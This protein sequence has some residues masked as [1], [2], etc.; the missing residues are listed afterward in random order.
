MTLSGTHTYV[1]ESDRTY[2]VDPGPLRPEY[3]GALAEW[4]VTRRSERPQVSILLSHGHPDHSPGAGALKQ[5]LDAEVVAS[6]HMDARAAARAGVDRRFMPGE[7]LGSGSDVLEVLHAPGHAPDQMA[8]WMPQAGILF[9]GDT[10]LGEGSSLVAPPE[11]DMVEYMRTLERLRNLGPRL[12]LPGHGPIVT[13]P[14]AKIDEY[15]EHRRE[16]E[17]QLLNALAVGPSTVAGL[18]EQIYRDVDPALLDMASGSVAAQLVKLMD[19]G[20][21]RRSGEVYALTEA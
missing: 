18:V 5:L 17:R 9:S 10:I 15:I 13:D 2:V 14:Q 11:G 4:I 6:E 19:D 8:F 20:R 16:R 21:V 3:L 1:L 12:I 7:R